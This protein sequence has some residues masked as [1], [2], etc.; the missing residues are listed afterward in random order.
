MSGM[1]HYTSWLSIAGGTTRLQ[2]ANTQA[3]RTITQSLT[4]GQ[5]ACVHVVAVDR[6][7][8]TSPEQIQCA[9]ALVPPPMPVWGQLDSAVSVNPAPVGLTGLDTWLWLEPVPQSVTLEEEYEGIHYAITASPL[10]VDWEFGDGSASRL[11][12]KVAFGLAFPLPSPVSHMYSWQARAGYIIR[13]AVRY[14]VT[15][16]AQIGGAWTDAYPMGLI[17][18]DANPLVY[19]VMQAQ[20]E[21]MEIGA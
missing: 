7:G 3:P 6:V 9:A 10:G 12:R 20:P 16:K 18:R 5:S 13:A 4:A 8:N 15:W 2:Q 11:D 21:L 1:D 14:A 17:E 19:P